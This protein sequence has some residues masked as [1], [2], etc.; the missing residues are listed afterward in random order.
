MPQSLLMIPALSKTS[1]SKC[2]AFA[3]LLFALLT[4]FIA[5]VRWG[6]KNELIWG[7][8]MSLI[9]GWPMSPWHYI[10]FTNS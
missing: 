9:H 1:V 10:T 5:I 8:G 4:C 2:S 6:L 3:F 7:P